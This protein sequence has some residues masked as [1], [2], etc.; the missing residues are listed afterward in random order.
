MILR[1]TRRWGLYAS[2]S[3]VRAIARHHIAVDFNAIPKLSGHTATFSE[4]TCPPTRL[5]TGWP[6]FQKEPVF[7]RAALK[8]A[9]RPTPLLRINC[10][11][12]LSVHPPSRPHWK[13]SSVHPSI[14]LM[15][16]GQMDDPLRSLSFGRRLGFNRLQTDQTSVVVAEQQSAKAS[17][18]LQRLVRCAAAHVRDT[19][20][21]LSCLF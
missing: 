3:R 1:P 9:Q 4:M 5:K 13:L 7:P 18:E 10:Q 15:K 11:D 16:F 20:Q 14:L 17:G 12:L 19:L 21:T 6:T 8:P 2:D